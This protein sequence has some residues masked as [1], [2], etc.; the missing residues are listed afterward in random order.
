MLAVSFE[1]VFVIAPQ[2]W[3]YEKTWPGGAKPYRAFVS[4]PGHE[5]SS[6]DA[7]QYRAILLRGIA[8]GVTDG[9]TM[10]NLPGPFLYLGSAVWFGILFMI[11]DGTLRS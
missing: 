1:S 5:Y 11:T 4:V 9:R 8:V 10:Y 2:M 6:F 3:V 7:P